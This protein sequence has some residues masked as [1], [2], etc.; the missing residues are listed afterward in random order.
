MCS[1]AVKYSKSILFFRR[2]SSFLASYLLGL[3]NAKYLDQKG[4]DVCVC[5]CVFI[6]FFLILRLKSC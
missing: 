4:R 3:S 1:A 6:P 2:H 5:V